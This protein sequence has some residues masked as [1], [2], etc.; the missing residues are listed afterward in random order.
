[1]FAWHRLELG[2]PFE[3]VAST[4]NRSPAAWIPDFVQEPGGRVLCTI[5]LSARLVRRAE[6]G[7]GR[8][9][10]GDG[11]LT[12]PVS[13]RAAEADVLFPSFAGEVQAARLPGDRTELALVGTYQ[14]PLGPVGELVDHAVLHRV[15]GKALAGFVARAGEMLTASAAG[16]EGPVSTGTQA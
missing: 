4:I 14:P 8:V 5:A 11:W 10:S 13:F 15:A 16:T 2:L 12:V 3:Q 1:M 7:L 9:E 6:L